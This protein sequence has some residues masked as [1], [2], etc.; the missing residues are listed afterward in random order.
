MISVTIQ[1][2]DGPTTLRQIHHLSIQNT[3]AQGLSGLYAYEVVL[4]GAVQTL[5]PFHRQEDGPLVLVYKALSLLV[6]QT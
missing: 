2:T 5:R 4:D 6:D 3:G 1:V